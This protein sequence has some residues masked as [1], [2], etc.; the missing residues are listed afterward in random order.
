MMNCPANFMSHLSAALPNHLGLE[1][2]DPGR[3]PCFTWDSH[4]EDGWIVMG[5][6]PG[7][8]IEIDERKL[9]KIGVDNP[10]TRRGLPAGRREG[11]GLYEVPP[12]PDEVVWER[13]R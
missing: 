9:A 5:E 13:K 4:I 6:K 1:V 7:L 12:T 2:V 10:R 11:A 8:G 3:E